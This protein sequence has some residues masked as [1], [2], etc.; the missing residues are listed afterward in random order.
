MII[1]FKKFNSDFLLDFPKIWFFIIIISIGFCGFITFF[2]VSEN[3]KE[4]VDSQYDEMN[5]GDSWIN[6][7]PIPIPKPEDI[8]EYS[9]M[10]EAEG[11]DVILPQIETMQPRLH[12]YGKSEGENGAIIVELLGLPEKQNINKKMQV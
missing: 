8:A 9:Q 3:I 4:T 6:L 5:L 11:I 7:Q 1:I 10:Q 2:Q 12:L